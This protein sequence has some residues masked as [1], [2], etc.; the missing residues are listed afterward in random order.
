M[1][2]ILKEHKAL[3]ADVRKWF[4]RELVAK[5]VLSVSTNGIASN[6]DK[7][8]TPSCAI[9]ALVAKSLKATVGDKLPAQTA[10]RMFEEI[11]CEFLKKT[12]PLMQH[13][14]PGEW[15]IANL[16]NNNSVKTSSF[17][18]YEHLSHLSQVIQADSKLAMML[19]NDYIVSPDIVVSRDPC[20]DTAINAGCAL[21]SDSVC[22]KT[23]LRK[24]NNPLEIMHASVSAKWTMRSDRAQNSRT[25]ALNLIRNR[26]GRVPHIVVV[27]GEPLPSRIS[28]LALGTGDIDCMYHIALYELIAAVHEYGK[29]GREDMIELLD[30]MVEGNRLKDI[31]DLPLDLC[32]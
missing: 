14:R 5:G 17:V 31:S 24:K 29:D 27:T 13:L 18:Q 12:F 22:L 32:C 6:S 21:V 1:N 23:D 25:E 2:E 7:D 20:D 15:H 28:S 9:G 11:T 8:N 30:S 10:G 4:H 16:G 26:K 3:L 19:G